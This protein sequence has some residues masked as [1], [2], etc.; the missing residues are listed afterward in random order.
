MESCPFH[1]H[2]KDSWSKF[3]PQERERRNGYDRFLLTVPHVKVRWR[4]IVVIH[5]NDD[6]EEATDFRDL[7]SK[8][9]S[10]VLE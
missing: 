10:Y 4:V 2:T 9:R 8:M 5:R 6:A 1:Y 3:P 7:I